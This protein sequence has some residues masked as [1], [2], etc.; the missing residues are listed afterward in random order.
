[1]SAQTG[2]REKGV[3]VMEELDKNLY[4]RGLCDAVDFREREMCSHYIQFTS[5]VG[6]DK[7]WE[8]DC[9]WRKKDNTCISYFAKEQK[10]R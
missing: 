1:M 9:W 5:N 3:I 7:P 4:F 2:K 6:T 10:S 8:I